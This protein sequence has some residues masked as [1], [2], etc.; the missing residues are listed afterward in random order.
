MMRVK[1][2]QNNLPKPVRPDQRM[3]MVMQ[4]WKRMRMAT[5]LPELPEQPGQVVR[6]NQLRQRN[7]EVLPEKPVSLIRA[8]ARRPV[9]N[10]RGAVPKRVRNL[11]AAVQKRLPH[12]QV[13]IQKRLLRVDQ[14]APVLPEPLRQQQKQLLQAD[15]ELGPAIL[16]QLLP[17]YLAVKIM[18]CLRLV[19]QEPDIYINIRK[20]SQILHNCLIN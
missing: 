4:S 20:K 6:S 9:H 15:Q 17:R 16:G 10:I 2:V 11:Q 1:A 3:R 7:R 19:D 5:L 18:K 8:V 13:I 14:E 12:V